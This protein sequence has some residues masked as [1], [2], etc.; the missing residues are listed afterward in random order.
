MTGDPNVP[1]STTSFEIIEERPLIIPEEA[2]SSN[3]ALITYSETP[4]FGDMSVSG[5]KE[6]CYDF[7]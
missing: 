5:Q 4:Q 3:Q 7:K 2:Q 6:F 1:F